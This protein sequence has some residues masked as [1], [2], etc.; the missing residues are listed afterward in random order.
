MFPAGRN[1]AH[2]LHASEIDNFAAGEHHSTTKHM[3]GRRSIFQAMNTT[4]TLSDVSANRTVGWLEGS[5]T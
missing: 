2:Q 4:C 5:G 1:R 3:V